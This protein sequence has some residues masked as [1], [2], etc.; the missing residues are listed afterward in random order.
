MVSTTTISEQP[1]RVLLVGAGAVGKH[2]LLDA[3]RTQGLVQKGLGSYPWRLDTK[4]YSADVLVE[5]RHVDHCPTQQLE[6]GGYEAVVLVFEAGRQAS[7]DSVQRWYQAVDQAV[8]EELG[9][10]LAV[11]IRRRAVLATAAAAAA[12]PQSA[13][14]EAAEDWCAK[15]LVEYVEAEEAGR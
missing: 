1:G 4:Y 11:C 7:F 3:I 10:K 5:V 15:Q 14:L 12:E 13:W 9:V 6:A 2:A 8:A